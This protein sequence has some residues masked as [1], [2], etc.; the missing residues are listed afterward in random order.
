MSHRGQGLG[1][2]WDCQ[3]PAGTAEVPGLRKPWVS[4]G[5]HLPHP[6]TH[7]PSQPSSCPT[8][9][10]SSQGSS[11]SEGLSQQEWTPVLESEGRREKGGRKQG[12][13]KEKPE[14]CGSGERG[15]EL[16]KLGDRV[17]RETNKEKRFTGHPTFLLAPFSILLP[18]TT[19]LLRK[20]LESNENVSREKRGAYVKGELQGT[21]A[22][23]SSQ[24]RRQEQK[25]WMVSE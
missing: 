4:P 14:E 10:L 17:T 6:A 20:G 15:G 12:R 22:T 25:I 16:K 23:L 18:R 11:P 24:S 2:R 21:P 5:L 9:T 1:R 13:K 3:P 19:P 7:S 8:P